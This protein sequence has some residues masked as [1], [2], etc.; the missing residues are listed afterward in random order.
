M[1]PRSSH[2]LVELDSGRF[3]ALKV[4][5]GSSIAVLLK[6]LQ[7]KLLRYVDPAN[8]TRVKLAQTTPYMSN[9]ITI[10][11]S[12]KTRKVDKSQKLPAAG[13]RSAGSSSTSS[14]K[15]TTAIGTAGSRPSPTT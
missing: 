14:S 6:L 5:Q 8:T 9:R 2:D 12:V 10:R 13:P 7:Q 3:K 1:T 4:A 15:S 11:L